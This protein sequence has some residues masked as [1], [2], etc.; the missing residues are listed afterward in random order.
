MSATT[1]ERIMPASRAGR[2]NAW[3]LSR[4]TGLR[5]ATFAG[6]LVALG[7]VGVGVEEAVEVADGIAVVA[8]LGLLA[9]IIAMLL[10]GV[11]VQRNAE[12][13]T[14]AALGRA[15]AAEAG[16]RSRADELARILVASESLALTGGRPG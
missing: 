7:L 14:R 5:T 9:T 11:R 3:R 8:I 13:R 4:K 16:E 10:V 6:V 12:S 2:P 15:V 1:P